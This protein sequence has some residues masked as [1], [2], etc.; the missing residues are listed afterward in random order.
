MVFSRFFRKNDGSALIEF[1]IVAPVF[2]LILFGVTEFG[3]FMYNKITVER[4]AVEV[5]R[6]A[7]IA[8][9]VDSGSCSGTSNQ[10]EYIT[11]IVREKSSALINGDRL[12]VQIGRVADGGTSLPDICLD[13]SANPSSAPATCNLYEDVDGNGVYRG[14]A[15]SNY[16]GNGDTIEVQISY[17]WSVQFPL[18]NSYFGSASNKGIAMIAA[19]TTIK[20]EP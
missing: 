1:A 9:T 18:L 2:L 12:Q 8:K 6:I 10:S 20:N 13:D 5:S 11:C 7:S 14:S 15:A 16:G 19:S 17:P 3:L 4:I